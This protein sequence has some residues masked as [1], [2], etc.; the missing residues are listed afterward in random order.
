M[1]AALHDLMTRAEGLPCRTDPEPYFSPNATD[2]QYATRQC[3]ACPLLLACMKYALTSGQE[4]GVWGG[5]DFEA[6]A[7]G[8]GTDRGY[9]THKRR[10]ELPC[11]L[12]ESAHTEAV[13]ADRR[14]RLAEEHAAGGTIRGYWLHRRL[15]EEACVPCKRACARQSRERRERD[16]ASAER[17]RGDVVAL[18]PSDP[19]HGPQAPT[20]RLPLTA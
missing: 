7:L 10:G 4:Y 15:E 12:C 1:T 5:V 11:R 20:Q 13:E 6:R 3:H 16:R 8:C 2:R 14:Q 9:R 17:E 18:P 19:F